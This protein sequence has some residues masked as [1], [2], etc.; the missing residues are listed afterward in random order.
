MQLSLPGMTDTVEDSTGPGIPRGSAAGKILDI[1]CTRPLHID[2]ISL[3]CGLMPSETSAAILD[4]ELQGLV[5]DRGGKNFV[6][7]G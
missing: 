4:L 7:V 1:L 5:E 3:A 2:D 6:R